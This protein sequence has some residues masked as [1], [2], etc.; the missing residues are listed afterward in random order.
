MVTPDYV[1]VL[2]FYD[3]QTNITN[4]VV[5]TVLDSL[6]AG[7]TASATS[8]DFINM[9]NRQR[10]TVIRDKFF[11]LPPMGV[12]GVTQGSTSILT[13]WDNLHWEEFINLKSLGTQYNVTDGGSIADITSGALSMLVLSNQENAANDNQ[14]WQ[15]SF[16]T[17]LKFYDV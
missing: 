5:S 7:G 15:V 13:T 16:G 12:N 11:Y 14:A 9:Q 1:R 3:R 17:R 10:F 4:P 2:I 8:G 6:N